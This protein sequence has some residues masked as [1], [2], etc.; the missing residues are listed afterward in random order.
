[1]WIKNIN[2]IGKYIPKDGNFHNIQIMNDFLYI[3]GQLAY[4]PPYHNFNGDFGDVRMN[5]RALTKD[6]IRTVYEKRRS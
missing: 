5:E 4:Q 6:E 3:D 1:M 2:G